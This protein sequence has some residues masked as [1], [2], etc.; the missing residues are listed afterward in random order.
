MWK[1]RLSIIIVFILCLNII[2]YD[3]IKG[4]EVTKEI[5]LDIESPS[6]VLMEAKSGK[7][8]FE[9]NMNEKRFPASTTKIMTLL[10]IYEAVEKGQISWEDKVVVSEH[11]AGMG[12]SQVFLEQNEEQTVLTMTK[13]IAVASANDASVA[14]AEHIA[15]SEEEFVKMMN[16]KAKQLGMKNTNFVNSSGLHDDAHV[17]S[18]YDIA[19]MSRELITRYPEVHKLTT[20][21][22]DNI[23]H[24]TRR[25]EEEFGLTNTNNLFKWYQGANGLKTG[26]TPESMYCLSGTAERDGLSL[27]SVV[28]GSKSKQTRNSE[29][30]KMLNYGFANFTIIKGDPAGK[31]VGTVEVAKGNP[32]TVDCIIK[33]DIQLLVSKKLANEKIESKIEL[34]EYIQAPITKDMKLGEIIYFFKG[35]E[36][37]RSDIVAADNV[38]KASFKEMLNSLLKRWY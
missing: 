11:A 31:V 10:L 30:A 5:A 9:K 14:M 24:K 22:Q 18:A 25:G 19:L 35:K 32:K 17:T 15:G 1:K 28:M 26:F 2:S 21:W 38:K 23:I 6:A 36:V 27:I 37:G 33:K 29:V 12:G 4:E 34:P 8:L 3:F 13:C 16:E 20:I 7:V